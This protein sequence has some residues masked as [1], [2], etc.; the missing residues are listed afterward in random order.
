[1]KIFIQGLCFSYGSYEVLREINLEVLPGEMLSIIGPNGSGKSTFL[2]CL[3]RVLTPRQGTVF[4]DGQEASKIT[5][6]I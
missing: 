5:S 4:L 6:G 2:R 1:M 3:A